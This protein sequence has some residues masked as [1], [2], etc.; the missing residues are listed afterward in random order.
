ML[1]VYGRWTVCV[2]V[3]VGGGGG[4]GEVSP[5]YAVRPNNA[6]HSN[7][8]IADKSAIPIVSLSMN[9]FLAC[10]SMNVWDLPCICVMAS[11]NTPTLTHYRMCDLL[12]IGTWLSLRRKSEL[13]C[14]NSTHNK[15]LLKPGKFTKSVSWQVKYT[16][17]CAPK[18]L[19]NYD[20][21][22]SL[23]TN[24]LYVCNKFWICAVIPTSKRSFHFY[25]RCT[26]ILILSNHMKL[27]PDITGKQIT[28]F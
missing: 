4:E 15:V 3:C 19:R 1:R 12:F 7:S 8:P 23:Q 27:I 11:R 9:T 14:S 6:W 5:L 21:I 18:S 26:K 2:C 17:F 10:V 22:W 25:I 20:K 28:L 13:T 24:I 16:F